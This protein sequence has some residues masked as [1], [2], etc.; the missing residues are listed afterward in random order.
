MFFRLLKVEKMNDEILFIHYIPKNFRDKIA[1]YVVKFMRFFADSFFKKRY[2][3]RAV[4]LET[5]AAIPGMV[6]A[7]LKHLQCLRRIKDD[8]GWIQTLLEEAENE[9]MHL[10]V[11]IHIAQPTVLER[12]IIIIVQALF[13]AFY[14]ILY[15]CSPYTAHR[16]VGYLEEEAI[17]SYSQYLTEV[18]E[19][20]IPNVEIPPLAH[21]YWGLGKE[22]RLADLIR[23]VRADEAKHRDVNHLCAKTLIREKGT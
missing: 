17:V 8:Q 13:F 7:M 21:S 14:L 16:L 18:E 15:L 4:V 11:F 5:V 1:Y 10:M 20:R 12:L 3:H 22:S 6:G 23:V 19:G 9:R 2:G